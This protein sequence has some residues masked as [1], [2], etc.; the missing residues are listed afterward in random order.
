MEL[1]VPNPKEA[2]TIL[3]HGRYNIYRRHKRTTLERETPALEEREREDQ[4]SNF[5]NQYKIWTD[6]ETGLGKII[7]SKLLSLWS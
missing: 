1:T 2:G 7:T 6:S 3:S 5:R 4:I